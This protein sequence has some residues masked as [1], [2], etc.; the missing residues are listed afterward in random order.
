MRVCVCVCVC[1]CVCNLFNYTYVIR[2]LNDFATP[3]VQ[4]LPGL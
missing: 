3:K 4:G 1:L 2:F